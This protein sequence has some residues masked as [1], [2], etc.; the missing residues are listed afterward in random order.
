M[1]KWFTLG[2]FGILAMCGAATAQDFPTRPVHLFVGF[3]AGGSAD[4]I[5]RLLANE[6]QKE[7]QQPMVV[8]N[9][10]G[11][12]G[13]VATAALARAPA[14]G[15]TLMMA[16]SQHVTNPLLNANVNYDPV[17][18]FAPISLVASSPLAIV[19]SPGFAASDVPALLAMAK[20]DPGA[21]NYATNG[22]GSIQHLSMEM[23]NFMAK[24]KMTHIPY[25]GGAPVLNDLLAGR[26]PLAIL[27]FAQALPYVQSKQLK[28][29]GVTSA[30]RLSILP[31]VP[32]L[33]ESGV[34]GYDTAL[35]FGVIAP[36]GTPDAI[37]DK[38]NAA[39]VKIVNTPEMRD[40]IITQGAQ[41]I[42]STR[43]EFLDLIKRE[44]ENW[45]KLFK[46]TGLKIE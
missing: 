46:E 20:K 19:A 38:I 18:D 45:S 34:P 28:V 10:P 36:A 7:W 1:T 12:N 9:R 15:Y 29:I 24:T 27:S 44:T 8:E 6:I 42:G 41:P 2:L 43:Q 26:V 35:W 39:V 32:T 25:T 22:I 3:P 23:L 17:K 13:V 40:R 5:A 14:D 31:D 11:A 4:I 37:L 16:L 33:A 21:V 30:E